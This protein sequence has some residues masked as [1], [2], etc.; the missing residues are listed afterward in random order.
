MPEDLLGLAPGG[1]RATEQQRAAGSLK[2]PP[3][4]ER[5]GGASATSHSGNKPR[6]SFAEIIRNSSPMFSPRAAESQEIVHLRVNKATSV[7]VY[8][9]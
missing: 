6:I 3:L 4:E 8:T 9:G 1:G 7:S 5:G 2:A